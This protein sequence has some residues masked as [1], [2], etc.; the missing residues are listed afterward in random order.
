MNEYQSLVSE[1]CPTARF[2]DVD[3]RLPLTTLALVWRGQATL[4]QTGCTQ[5]C[6]RTEAL[7]Q[8]SCAHGGIIRSPDAEQSGR[9]P[10][11]CWPRLPNPKLLYG[12][13]CVGCRY[14]NLAVEF[15]MWVNT[16]PNKRHEFYR[17]PPPNRQPKQLA[18]VELK[19]IRCFSC[20]FF[21][22]KIVLLK[23]TETKIAGN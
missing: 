13:T 12:R 23:I 15:A 3:H 14:V 4:L 9:I 8:W 17:G 1:L 5:P 18:A 19:K 2:Y 20:I 21:V 10:V 11:P 7:Q 22:R 16:P 6:V